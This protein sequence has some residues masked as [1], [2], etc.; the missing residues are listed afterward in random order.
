[1]ETETETETETAYHLA[2]K[3][4]TRGEIKSNKPRSWY[5]LYGAHGFAVD[6]G[7][8]HLR[9]SEPSLAYAPGSTIAAHEYWEIGIRYAYEI[10]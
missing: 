5:K 10:H 2:S 9:H 7:R 8:S 1:M 4:C 6:F 3:R